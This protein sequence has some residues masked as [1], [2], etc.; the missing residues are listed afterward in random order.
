MQRFLSHLLT[1]GIALAVTAWVLPG[2]EIVSIPALVVSALVLGFVNAVVRPI[3]FVLTLP[4]TV[5]T[6]GLF[7][8]VINGAAFGLAAW[9]VPGFNVGSLGWAMVGALM[10]SVVSWFVGS[11]GPERKKSR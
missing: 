7:Y 1:V 5:V 9:L 10:V 3:L 2:V 6:L 11:F 4:I 8:L